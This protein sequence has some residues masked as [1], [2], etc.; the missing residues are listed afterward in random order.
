MPPTPPGHESGAMS[1][2]GLARAQQVM[3]DAGVHPTA[4]EV[5]SHYYGELEGGATGVI[6]EDSIRPLT[7]PPS[8]EAADIDEEEARAEVK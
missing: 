4:I 8:L 5:F 2:D 7:D 6:L 3:T 1:H